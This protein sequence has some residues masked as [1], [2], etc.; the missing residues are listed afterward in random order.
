MKRLKAISRSSEKKTA[1]PRIVK[2]C[3]ICKKLLDKD[4]EMYAPKKLEHEKNFHGTKY[5]KVEEIRKNDSAWYPVIK[6]L[7][8]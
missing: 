4:I 8:P 3:V 1:A 6:I 5:F 2:S 7:M